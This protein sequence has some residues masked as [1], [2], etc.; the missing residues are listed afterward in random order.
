MS[1]PLSP[2]LRAVAALA[3]LFALGT[4]AFVALYAVSPYALA[5]GLLFALGGCVG[6]YVALVAPDYSA[7]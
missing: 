2:A 7:G 3:S 5:A 6:L 1:D 4:G